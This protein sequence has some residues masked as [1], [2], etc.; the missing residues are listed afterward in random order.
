VDDLTACRLRVENPAAIDGRHDASDAHRAE[1]RIDVDFD[2]VG[3]V[4]TGVRAGT[5]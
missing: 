1:I 5:G 4:S 3:G 2:E